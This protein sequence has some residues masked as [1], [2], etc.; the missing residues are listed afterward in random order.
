MR[1]ASGDAC[2]MTPVLNCVKLTRNGLVFRVGYVNPETGLA[3]ARVGRL[4]ELSRSLVAL[5]LI[6]ACAR[7]PAPQAPAPPTSPFAIHVGFWL[8]LHLLLYAQSGPRGARTAPPI[9]T[10]G[11]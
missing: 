4:R 3:L 5:A 6:A 11:R 9:P 8:N 2:K 1:S 7:A 10:G